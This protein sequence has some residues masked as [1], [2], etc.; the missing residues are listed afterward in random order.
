MLPRNDDFKSQPPSGGF[1]LLVEEPLIDIGQPRVSLEGVFAVAIGQ[2][3][4]G[5]LRQKSRDYSSRNE[6]QFVD[7]IQLPRG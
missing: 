3:I 6:L 2:M 7:L 1:F 5:T 4:I